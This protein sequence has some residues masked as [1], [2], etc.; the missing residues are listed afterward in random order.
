MVQPRLC[1]PRTLFQKSSTPGSLTI[2]S[3]SRLSG[4]T[5]KIGLMSRSHKSRSR[6]CQICQFIVGQISS[7]LRINRVFMCSLAE[8]VTSSPDRWD[9][10]RLTRHCS[11]C[12]GS[13]V[14]A[15]MLEDEVCRSA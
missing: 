4:T 1:Q 14:Q 15:E 6:S 2:N 13:A 7:N 9:L 11:D 10:N 3:S 5:A 12:L 8:N